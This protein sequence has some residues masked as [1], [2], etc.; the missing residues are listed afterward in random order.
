MLSSTQ[1][2]QHQVAQTLAD[3]TPRH[4]SGL[5]LQQH[6]L[7]PC[8]FQWSLQT[9]QVTVSW[10]GGANESVQNFWRTSR[11][12]ALPVAPLEVTK[13]VFFFK[14]PCGTIISCWFSTAAPALA[15][16]RSS[17]MLPEQEETVSQK[18][19]CW[20]QL[21]GLLWE[22]VLQWLCLSRLHRSLQ[23]RA[24]CVPSPVLSFS[25]ECYV[26]NSDVFFV[27]PFKCDFYL[28]TDHSKKSK[29]SVQPGT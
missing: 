23:W 8:C 18:S 7:S 29:V 9:P 15:G 11:C 25:K 4:P 26:M 6:K 27:P 3:S 16:K 21:E 12:P 2:K 10:Q 5:Y 24:A 17:F 13:T 1:Q 28:K 14:L 20:R 19:S 22:L